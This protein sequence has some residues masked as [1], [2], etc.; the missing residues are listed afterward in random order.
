MRETFIKEKIP[1]YA[2]AVTQILQQH[3]ASCHHAE[4]S[5][6]SVLYHHGI[7]MCCEGHRKP[8]CMQ[9]EER[10]VIAHGF[11]LDVLWKPLD[12]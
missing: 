4:H 7:R 12:K 6:E 9:P 3:F 10:E 2:P 5:W 11:I 8:A 1:R